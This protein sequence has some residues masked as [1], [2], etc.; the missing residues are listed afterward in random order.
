MTTWT[1]D[2]DLD[3]E[4][5]IAVQVPLYS[6]DQPGEPPRQVGIVM[7]TDVYPSVA[8]RAEELLPD[9]VTFLGIGL[10]LG[11]LGA[12][13][14]ARLI[15]RRTRG[16]EPAEI[17]AL[18]D[19]R[20]ALLHSIR[21]GVV[22]VATDGTVTVLSDSARELVGLPETALGRKVDDLDLDPGLRAA[23]VGDDEVQDRVLVL[24]ERVVVLN[25]NRVVNGGRQVGTVTTLRDRTELMAM[26][27]ELTRAREHHRDAA[28]ADPRVQ[29]PAAHDLRPGP[30][31]GVRR[32]VPRDRGTD[33]AAGG[34]QRGRDQAGRRTRPW[35]RC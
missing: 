1:G 28:R 18:A 33:P 31:R 2:L 6:P 25:R 7:V 21:E 19:Q 15:K 3:G 17:A 10:G 35:P 29:Q 14:L 22:A 27:S 9:L 34:D 5:S 4:H 12:W 30:A 16:L 24:G 32:G 26:Q 8:D 13:L 23:L 20:E 11:L